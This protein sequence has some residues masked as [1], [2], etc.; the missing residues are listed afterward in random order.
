MSEIFFQDI[1]EGIGFGIQ[2]CNVA[3]VALFSSTGYD[4]RILLF[5][6]NNGPP[7]LENINVGSAFGTS[8]YAV[9]AQN[10]IYIGHVTEQ[11]NVQKVIVVQGSNVGI[12]TPFPSAALQVTAPINGYG[13]AF[14]VNAQN[15]INIPTFRIRN[16][17]LVGVGTDPVTGHTMTV[18]GVLKVDSLIIGGNVSFGN[19]GLLTA[20]GVVSSSGNGDSNYLQFGDNSLCNL[21][22]I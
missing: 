9:N 2:T 13:D 1:D 6:A 3:D 20:G 19:A 17:G 7:G 10:E 11:S 14:L 16:D 15:G 12:N 5:T 4:A 22:N 18:K 21:T 8:N